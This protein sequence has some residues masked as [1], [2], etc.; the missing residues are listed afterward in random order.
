MDG[1][2]YHVRTKYPTLTRSFEIIEGQNS[3]TALSGL[4][5]RDIIGT[6]Y[7]YQLEVERDPQ[8]PTDYDNFFNA[9]SS[10]VSSHEITMPYGQGTITYN[11]KVTSGSDTYYG[12]I[13]GYNRWSG[14]TVSFDC[15]EPQIFPSNQ[16]G[17]V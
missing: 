7:S 15:V 10:P 13:A 9:I 17:T 3:G 1:T 8:Y 11:A 14:L 5:I 4:E 12:N 2:L 16:S 6:G